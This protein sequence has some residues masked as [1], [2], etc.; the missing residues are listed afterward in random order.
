MPKEKNAL[1]V[2]VFGDEYAEALAE[3]LTRAFYEMPSIIVVDKN[4]GGSGLVDKK[5]A[6]W[7]AKLAEAIK[8]ERVDFAVI[9]LGLHDRN[10]IVEDGETIAFRGEGWE[11]AYRKRIE[12]LLLSARDGGKPVYWVGLPPTGD[13]DMSKDFSH[14]ND[15]Y[16][17]SV[18]AVGGRFID[19]WDGFLDAEH[20]F[21]RD[22]PDISGRTVAL[23]HHDGINFTKAGRRKLAYFIEREIRRDAGLSRAYAG[24]PTGD[25]LPPPNLYTGD[26]RDRPQVGPMLSLTR[27]RLDLGAPLLGASDVKL[28]VKE[29]SP[30]YW[31]MVRG[32][33]LYAPGGRVDDFRWP[34]PAYG[35]DPD[36][37]LPDNDLESE[38]G[39]AYG[40]VSADRRMVADGNE[41]SAIIGLDEFT[42]PSI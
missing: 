35:D 42:V 34:P 17:E 21:V 26:W 29:D 12:A 24:A 22:G 6:D 13:P 20:Q 37:E 10:E 39:L 5:T 15:L 28:T 18:Y 1:V 8:T 30:P 23:R 9:M 41:K 14:L 31:L 33:A 19:I 25:N 2:A 27:P 3:G 32:D 38:A 40:V 16:R 7:P 11:S 4:I 36:A